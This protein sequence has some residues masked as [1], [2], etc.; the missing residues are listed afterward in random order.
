MMYEK[1]IVTNKFLTPKDNKYNGGFGEDIAAYFAEEL[2]QTGKY[3]ITNV[4][5]QDSGFGF[6]IAIQKEKFWFS[7]ELLN[8]RNFLWKITVSPVGLAQVTFFLMRRTFRGER[9]IKD[10][11]NI[12]KNLTVAKF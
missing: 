11:E 4:L 1:K 10:I 2:I 6:W 12:T 3:T 8:T 9:I 5:S 7:I